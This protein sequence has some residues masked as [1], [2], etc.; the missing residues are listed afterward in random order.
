MSLFG[1]NYKKT[2]KLYIYHDE[3]GRVKIDK[4]FFTGL[5]IFPA[6][7]FDDLYCQLVEILL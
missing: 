1:D 4:Y 6:D 7:Y 3:S 5:L 2:G